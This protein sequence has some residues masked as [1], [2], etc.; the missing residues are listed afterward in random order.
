MRS[1]GE[2]Y[3]KYKAL[4]EFCRDNEIDLCE[5]SF[6]VGADYLG[7]ICAEDREMAE[8]SLDGFKKAALAA[9]LRNHDSRSSPPEEAT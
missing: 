9:Y 8:R 7:S 1:S 3:E 4:Y 5:I 2:A 6:V